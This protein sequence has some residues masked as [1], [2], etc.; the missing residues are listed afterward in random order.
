MRCKKKMDVMEKER[1]NFIYGSE[2]ENI[3]GALKSGVDEKSAGEVFDEMEKMLDEMQS[4]G[5]C[6]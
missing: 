5:D 3:P 4:N 1:K 2:E 6:K